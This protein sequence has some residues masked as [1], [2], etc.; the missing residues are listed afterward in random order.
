MVV[1]GGTSLLH[2]I[3]DWP[4][5]LRFHVEPA[6]R[7]SERDAGEI[8]ESRG[9]GPRGRRLQLLAASGLDVRDPE[10]GRD[11]RARRRHIDIGID[12]DANVQYGHE[13]NISCR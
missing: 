4:A 1:V 12:M 10:I 3:G 8:A 13:C 7:L 5:F 9:H 11:T 2:G 6:Q